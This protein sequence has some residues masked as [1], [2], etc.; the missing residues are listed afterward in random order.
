MSVNSVQGHLPSPQTIPNME[1]PIASD[2]EEKIKNVAQKAS[3]DLD[4]S[5]QNSSRNP[6]AENHVATHEKVLALENEAKETIMPALEK[7]LDRK[8]ARKNRMKRSRP[9][10]KANL[11]KLERKRANFIPKIFKVMAIALAPTVGLVVA[12]VLVLPPVGGVIAVCVG[13]LFLTA[14]CLNIYIKYK[15]LQKLEQ[16][17]S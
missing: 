8:I 3:V 9:I 10:R 5:L 2:S 14:V 11:E 12:A 17:W 16:Q 13:M 1:Q 6:L 7:D 15:K 4:Q